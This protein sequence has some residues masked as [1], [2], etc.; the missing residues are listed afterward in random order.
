MQDAETVLAII[1]KRGTEGQNLEGIF[2]QLFNPDLYLRAYGRIYRNAGSM[3]KGTTDETVDGMSQR[4]IEGIIE[5]LRNERFR[6]TPVRR[7]LIPKKNGKTRPLGIPQWTDKL[8]QEVM[9][10]ILEAYY[11]PQFSPLSHGFRPDMGCHTALKHIYCAWSGTVWLIEGDIKGCFDNI[12]HTIMLSILREKIHD[13]RILNLIGNLLKAGY[14]EQW[15]YRTTLS[16]TP[17]GGVISPLFANI[18]LDK[19][20]KFVEQTLFPK[21]NRGERKKP[22]PVYNQLY[23]K[24]RKLDAEGA[25]E[26]TLKSLRQEL[27]SL[28]SKDHF[29]PNYRRLRYTRYADDF[30]LGFDGP[31]EEAEEIRTLI[32]AFLRDHLKLELSPEK[33]LI[34]HALNEKARFLGY[35]VSTKNTPGQRGH[36][37]ISLGIP[38][39]VL[40]EKIARYSAE[41]VPIHRPE[42][43]GENDFAIVNLYGQ[44]FR[45]YAQFYAY[46]H[47]RH[48]LNRLQWYMETSLLKTLAAKHKSTVQKMAKRFAGRAI[49]E[50]GVVKCFSVT[51][52]RKD[53]PP[54]Y[55]KFGGISLK[56]QPFKMI[57]DFSPGQDRLFSRSELIQRLLADECE[58]CGSRDRVQSHHVRKL[59]DLNVK[60]RK[61][62]PIWRQVMISRKRKTL[63]VCH[64]C[65]TAIHAGRPTRTRS[66]Q[67]AMSEGNPLE[68]RVL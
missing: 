13:N 35:N 47:N 19:L 57:E 17:Q 56:T 5:L 52:E 31:K 28:G 29:D 68:S 54:L 60:G 41:G 33:T 37:T 42:L 12:D 51:I 21:F 14:L 61:E 4:K 7:I 45:G 11:E 62:I 18:Y 15:T 32:G 8:L 1:R 66:S 44:E 46:A 38:P 53:K 58:L 48:W 25:S 3:T 67:E 39:D 22:N 49:T 55:T 9:R 26:A 43:I 16:G 30:L 36:Q 64:Y 59:A 23:A 10:S 34:T 40:E 24:I 6:W 63:L 65:H 27:R 50:N 2:R 20:D